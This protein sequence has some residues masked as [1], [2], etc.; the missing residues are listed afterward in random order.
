ME[1]RVV[2]RH[3][4]PEA[5]ESY[6]VFIQPWRMS[7]RDQP[8]SDGGVCILV[9]TRL[10]ASG[11]GAQLNDVGSL[12]APV[13]WR[14]VYSRHDTGVVRR[15]GFSGRKLS[16]SISVLSDGR[17]RLFVTTWMMARRQIE[18][19][20]GD[21]GANDVGG[22]PDLVRCLAVYSRHHIIWPLATACTGHE[23]VVP[24]NAGSLGKG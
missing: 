7:G 17:R 24:T 11:G 20:A 8:V 10:E 4:I 16:A 22:F 13:R 14:C 1:S 12:L 3:S 6:S 5:R 9:T 2:T 18:C 15:V 23:R 21:S 19:G